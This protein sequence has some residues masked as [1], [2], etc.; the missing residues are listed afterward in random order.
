MLFGVANRYFPDNDK[1]VRNH[2]A[3]WKTVH[4]ISFQMYKV[5]C[6]LAYPVS[7]TMTQMDQFVAS[8]QMTPSVE[9]EVFGALNNACIDIMQGL[10]TLTPWLNWIPFVGNVLSLATDVFDWIDREG[11]VKRYRAPGTS[12][13]K[14][15]EH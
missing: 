14:R 13:K 9:W 6:R 12:K 8:K 7:E 3:P 4:D 2:V 10:R 11:L 15:K 1:E 5:M